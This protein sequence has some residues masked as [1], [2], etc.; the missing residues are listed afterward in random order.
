MN[1]FGDPFQIVFAEID[2]FKRIAN[3]STGRGGD[4]D[5]VGRG[6]SLQTRGQIRRAAHRQ[7]GLV[8]RPGRFTDDDRTG[9]DADTDRQVLAWTRPA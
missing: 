8:P 3:Q 7:L 1:G 5:L 9:G 6:Q 2:Q 4:D